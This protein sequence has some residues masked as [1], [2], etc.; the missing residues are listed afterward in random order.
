M[1]PEGTGYVEELYEEWKNSPDAVDPRWGE[2]FS[3]LDGEVAVGGLADPETAVAS[4]EHSSDYAYKQ[5]RVNALLWAYRDVGAIYADINPLEAYETPTMRYMR[6]TV[7]GAFETL[8]LQAFGLCEGDLNTEFSTGGH[9]EPKRAPLR[10]IIELAETTYLST[11][12]TEF[13]HI[14]NRVM[15]RWLLD[16]IE[17]PRYRSSWTKEQRIRFQKDLIKA[18]HFEHFVHANFI[19]QKRFSLEGGEALIPAVH[20]LIYTA[21]E[22]SEPQEGAARSHTRRC[23]FQRSGC[24]SGDVQP[25]SAQRIPDGGY[26][27]HHREQP[28]RVHH[29]EQR[30]PQHFFCYRFRQVLAGTYLPRQRRRSRSGGSGGGPRHALATEVRVRRGGGYRLLP[31]SRP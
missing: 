7:E 2:Y 9:F 14:R 23:R 28:D 5:S 16:H 12:G 6:I 4:P 22:G 30:R 19:G 15:R 27:S 1:D 18:E 3:R 31:P 26:R 17:S 25:Q 20:Y 29:G 8:T 13:L 24:C 21:A 11:L 10:R